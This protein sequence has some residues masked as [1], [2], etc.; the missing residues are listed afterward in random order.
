MAPNTTLQFEYDANMTQRGLVAEV[1]WVT[2]SSCRFDFGSSGSTLTRTPYFPLIF[3][4]TIYIIPSSSSS[5]S[6]NYSQHGIHLLEILYFYLHSRNVPQQLH[7][8]RL[9]MHQLQLFSASLMVSSSNPSFSL[10]SQLER[11]ISE[12]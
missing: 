12:H 6:H 10:F 8:A 11:C 2:S 9:T 4:T 3:H 7:A 1:C 5:A